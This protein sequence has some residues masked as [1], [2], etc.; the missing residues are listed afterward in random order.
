MDIQ[1]RRILFRL[2][3]V[4]ISVASVF[5]LLDA[6]LGFT[7]PHVT[8]PEAPRLTS[9]YINS[10]PL[11]A[12]CLGGFSNRETIAGV[13]QVAAH[14]TPF[15]AYQITLTNIGGAA[16]KVQGVNV[17]LT[18]RRHEIFTEH[19]TELGGSGITLRPGQSRRLVEA[20]GIDQPVAAC[21]ILSWQS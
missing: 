13:T 15:N 19:Y 8:F 20:Y 10:A 6:M 18:G 3:D 7:G 21:E 12:S 9:L 1:R 17:G 5:F 4:I 16:L 14:G 2:A 11:S